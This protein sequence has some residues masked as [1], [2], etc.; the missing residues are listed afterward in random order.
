[1][2][3]KTSTIDR[4]FQIHTLTTLFVVALSALLID[5]SDADNSSSTTSDGTEP[6]A[7]TNKPP[8]RPKEIYV[9]LDGDGVPELLP[10]N[11]EDR[12]VEYLFGHDER[13]NGNGNPPE[14]L[15]LD[16]G[17]EWLS[18]TCGDWKCGDP[19]SCDAIIPGCNC[20]DG[21]NFDPEKGCFNNDNCDGDYPEDDPNEISDISEPEGADDNPLIEFD[22][23][24][25]I[26]IP[27]VVKEAGSDST[28]CVTGTWNGPD[29]GIVNSHYAGDEATNHHLLIFGLPDGWAD[30]VADGELFPCDFNA[31]D[32]HIVSPLYTWSEAGRQGVGERLK[33]GQRYYLELHTVNIFPHPILVNGGAK[34]LLRSLDTLTGISAPFLLGPNQVIVKPG[35]YHIKFT[36]KWP[37]DTSILLLQAHLHEYGKWFA[38]DWTSAKGTTRI[39]EVDPWKHEYV[40]INAPGHSYGVD[41]FK[42]SAGDTFTTHCR[43][44]NPTNADVKSPAEMCNTFGVAIMDNA[45]DQN[46]P[47]QVVKD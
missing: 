8:D 24:L 25:F 14:K 18:D 9:D 36:Y 41:E 16:T 35:D 28:T 4:C 1:M 11:V 2:V 17:G 31:N 20:N 37:A 19:P 29:I 12:R 6:Q 45:I 34:L 42:V 32:E 3:Q 47:F 30:H 5:C 40:S 10:S 15:C 26:E 13:K 22:D 33:H 23:E 43:W 21:K 46:M 44:F 27:A 39:L 38:I 7:D